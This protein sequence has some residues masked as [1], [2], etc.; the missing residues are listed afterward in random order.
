MGKPNFQRTPTFLPLCSDNNLCCRTMNLISK[1]FCIRKSRFRKTTHLQCH[2]FFSDYTTT[3]IRREE[4]ESSVIKQLFDC[5]TRK[6]FIAYPH[7]AI[8]LLGHL[9]NCFVLHSANDNNVVEQNCYH[10]KLKPLATLVQC[11]FFESLTPSDGDNVACG[12]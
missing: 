4:V 11:T 10:I 3:P 5:L 1:R 9:Q 7:V 8:Y 6:T 2:T 12:A